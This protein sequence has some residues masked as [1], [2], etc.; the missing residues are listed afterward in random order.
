MSEKEQIARLFHDTNGA[1]QGIVTFLEFLE[2]ETLP[3]EIRADLA[4]ALEQ[5]DRLVQLLRELRSRVN[6]ELGA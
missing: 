2:D 1:V 6:Q 4:S 3:D 5:S